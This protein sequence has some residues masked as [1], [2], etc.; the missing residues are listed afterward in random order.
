MSRAETGESTASL[1]RQAQQRAW[2][3]VQRLLAEGGRLQRIAQTGR[4]YVT[5]AAGAAAARDWRDG[6]GGLTD[7]SVAR[8][9]AEGRLKPWLRG[10]VLADEPAPAP[11]EGVR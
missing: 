4:W 1:R 8:L 6:L 7:A 11:A 9:V 2:E 5:F 3:Q 10:Y